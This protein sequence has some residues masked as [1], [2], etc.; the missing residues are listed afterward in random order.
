MRFSR[1]KHCTRFCGFLSLFFFFTL[2]SYHHAKRRN[3]RSL[4]LHP[5]PFKQTAAVCSAETLFLLLNLRPKH[6]T[7]GR[8]IALCVYSGVQNAL[9]LSGRMPVVM[10]SVGFIHRY[11]VHRRKIPKV[12]VEQRW[13]KKSGVR[14]QNLNWIL[15]RPRVPLIVSD[16]KSLE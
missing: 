1:I 2:R 8:I 12:F 7:S 14:A 13:G 16:H 9:I 3:A 6:G 5:K 15:S 4:F 11:E 10:R